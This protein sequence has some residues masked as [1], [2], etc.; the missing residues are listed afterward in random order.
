M[1]S[2]GLKRIGIAA[3]VF[4]QYVTT[5]VPAYLILSSSFL[6]SGTIR[7]PARV[8]LY[9]GAVLSF[10]LI[11]LLVGAEVNAIN[12]GTHFLFYFGFLFPLIA[13]LTNRG[14]KVNSLLSEKV[15]IGLCLLILLEAIAFNSPIAENLYFFPS[16]DS[17]DRVSLFGIY[18]RPMGVAGN[19]SMTA[20][21]LFFLVALVER[22][23]GAIRT[24]TQVMVVVTTLV[25]ASG[26]GFSLLLLYLLI[27]IG[28]SFRFSRKDWIRMGLYLTLFVL[29][30]AVVIE[31][32]FENFQKFSLDYAVLM[33][34]YKMDLLTSQWDGATLESVLLGNQVTHD[35]VATSGDT[36]FVIAPDAIGVVGACLLFMAPLLY[37]GSIRRNIIPTVYF[38]VSFLHYPGLLSPP[39]QVL[40]ACYIYMLARSTYKTERLKLAYKS[41]PV[42][43]QA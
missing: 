22:F 19:P 10:W 5:A 12:I 3:L 17:Q 27:S 41:M 20:V 2:G 25:L 32:Q 36:G 40:F 11:V 21:V 34:D 35:F 16:A 4:S 13:I 38:Y 37:A 23:R 8:L 9:L 28:R 24:R 18:Q 1:I 14:I 33:Y 42:A 26:M 15:I 43:E 6:V 31:G 30:L 7:I 29:G 39:G